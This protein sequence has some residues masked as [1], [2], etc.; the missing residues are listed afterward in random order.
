MPG[1]NRI[2]V[3]DMLSNL[4][5][6]K[7]AGKLGIKILRLADLWGGTLPKLAELKCLLSVEDNHNQHKPKFYSWVKPYI[8]SDDDRALDI[9]TCPK[10]S[11]VSLVYDC[12]LKS[13]REKREAAQSC[14][15][16]IGCIHRCSVCGCCSEDNEFYEE[17][18]Y[19]FFCQDCYEE[20]YEVKQP[21]EKIISSTCTVFIC[22]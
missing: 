8:L 1:C 22:G 4:R 20:F 5:D 10:C 19:N 21:V 6:M 18:Y 7:S 14:R 13:C 3:D 16:C 2:S 17:V 12:P 9:E 15:G 11:E